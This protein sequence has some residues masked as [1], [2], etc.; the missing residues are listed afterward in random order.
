MKALIVQDV[1]VAKVVDDANEP[2]L[3]PDYVKVKVAE[4]AAVA[5]NPTDW[6]TLDEIGRAGSI[7][8]KNIYS[9]CFP[10][11]RIEEANLLTLKMM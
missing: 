9:N 2:S 5:L 1:G 10:T 7:V 3:R 6:K 8:G 11:Y 4:V